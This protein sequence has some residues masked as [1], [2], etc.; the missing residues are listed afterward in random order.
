MDGDIFVNNDINSIPN[1]GNENNFF[2][3]P[4]EIVSAHKFEPIRRLNDYDYNILKD[5]AYKDITDEALKLEY[6]ISKIEDEIQELDNQI[7]SAK[8]I[9]DFNTAESLINMQKQLRDDLDGLLEIY[10]DSSLSAKISCGLVNNIKNKFSKINRNALDFAE[11]VI[12]KFPGK[13]SSILEIKKSLNKLE[14]INRSV[15]ELISMRTPYGE[16][17]DK[18]EQLSKYIIKANSIQSEISRSLK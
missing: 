3:Q 7:Q 18:Y 16:A 1:K 11:A 17:A 8:D 13:F 2:L 14:N 4:E 10:N 9:H 5:G 6:K 12:S 15:D